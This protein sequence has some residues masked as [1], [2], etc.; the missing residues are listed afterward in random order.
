MAVKPGV[1]DERGGCRLGMSKILLAEQGRNQ[2]GEEGKRLPGL[3]GE[4]QGQEGPPG[5]IRD[6]LLHHPAVLVKGLLNVLVAPGLAASIL[7]GAP[8]NAN[9]GPNQ[10]VVFP[11]GE[12]A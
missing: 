6:G 11:T 7:G 5:Q 2:D 4:H 3:L 12:H 10:Q 8:T 1:L 9:L